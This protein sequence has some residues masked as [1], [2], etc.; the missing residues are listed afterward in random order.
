MDTQGSVKAA[1]ATQPDETSWR[2][3][4]DALGDAV[5]VHDATT[6]EIR[7]VNRRFVELSGYSPEEARRLNIRDLAGD[8]HE[9]L[10]SSVPGQPGGLLEWQIK[11]RSGRQVRVEAH[12]SRVVLSKGGAG[13][14]GSPEISP[15]QRVEANR[16]EIESFAPLVMEG[17]LAGVYLIQ[18]EKFRYVNSMMAQKFGYRPEEI[19]GRF[20][21]LDLVH[22]EDREIAAASLRRR[23]TQEEA[24]AQYC[25]RG[26]RR[27][28][29]PSSIANY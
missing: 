7:E 12:L 27:V 19:I 10:A 18:D 23:L 4:L 21:P 1:A 26:R 8:G 16:A 25:L 28:T 6:G 22:P 29:G 5:L 20:G 15:R 24:I 9:P 14:R 13:L 3:I 17:A 2:A 11:D